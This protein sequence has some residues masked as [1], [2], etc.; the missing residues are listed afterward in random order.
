M[1][2]RTSHVPPKWAST[3]TPSLAASSERRRWLRRKSE[4]SRKRTSS[5]FHGIGPGLARHWR[6]KTIRNIVVTAHCSLT[7]Y[8]WSNTVAWCWVAR[9]PSGWTLAD[10]VS[11]STRTSR[12]GIRERRTNGD[13]PVDSRRV[14]TMCHRLSFSRGQPLEKHPARSS[15]YGNAFKDP[16]MSDGR[17]RPMLAH[18]QWTCGLMLG[19]LTCVSREADHVTVSTD[20]YLDVGREVLSWLSQVGG[21]L[22]KKRTS[23]SKF[24]YCYDIFR[25]K[26][27]QDFKNTIRTLNWLI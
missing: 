4:S 20:P 16:V 15:K 14:P 10:Q 17:A 8:R 24:K 7:F 23:F 3:P 18:A 1:L 6:R 9:R 11:S 19:R 21:N 5:N 13:S 2:S 12:S 27:F 25:N 26:F 22:N